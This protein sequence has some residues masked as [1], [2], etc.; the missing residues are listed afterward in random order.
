[1]HVA[2]VA[3]PWLPWILDGGGFSLEFEKII[4]LQIHGFDPESERRTNLVISHCLK[5]A[6]CNERIMHVAAA[7]DPW[8]R[9]ILD[10]GGFFARI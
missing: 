9:W 3:D 6:S 10:G 2:A 1:M 5:N 4:F 8:L 7:A